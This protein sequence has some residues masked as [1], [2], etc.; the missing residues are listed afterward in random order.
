MTALPLQHFGDQ[1]LLAQV[2]VAID[3]E[4]SHGLTYAVAFL[5]EHGAA[6]TRASYALAKV[7]QKPTGAPCANI[8]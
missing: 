3:L 8:T 7:S 2:Q 1:L 5:M 6:I 4:Q